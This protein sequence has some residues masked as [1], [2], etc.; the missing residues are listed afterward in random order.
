MNDGISDADV[1]VPDVGDT[2]AVV[3]GSLPGIPVGE[4]VGYGRATVVVSAAIA[5]VHVQATPAEVFHEDRPLPP[6]LLAAVTPLD[7]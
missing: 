1:P 7:P 2:V 6:L 5:D 4:V 3:S